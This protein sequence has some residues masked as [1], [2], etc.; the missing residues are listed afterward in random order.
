MMKK[1]KEEIKKYKFITGSI[2]TTEL[3]IFA[4][5]IILLQDMFN[6]TE[7]IKLLPQWRQQWV[8]L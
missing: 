3:F 6:G 2:V 7:K 1:I 8:F 5:L 4:G